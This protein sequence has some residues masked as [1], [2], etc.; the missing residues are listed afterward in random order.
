MTHEFIHACGQPPKPGLLRS[1]RNDVARLRRFNEILKACRWSLKKD[2]GK[3]VVMFDADG[4]LLMMPAPVHLQCGG[5]NGHNY[6]GYYDD[7]RLGKVRTDET[8]YALRSRGYFTTSI[9]AICDSTYSSEPL[10]LK[11]RRNLIKYLPTLAARL[12][13]LAMT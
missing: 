10:V 1:L 7:S 13:R 3:G 11:N 2:L 6:G 8:V 12:R 5:L 9:S 4:E